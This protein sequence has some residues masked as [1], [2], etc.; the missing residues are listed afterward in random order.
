MKIVVIAHY[1]LTGHTCKLF[2]TSEAKILNWKL[3]LLIPKWFG[4]SAR[5]IKNHKSS[6]PF[7]IMN[8]C[9]E[10]KSFSQWITFL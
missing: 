6:Y 8:V 5:Q 7:F 9:F 10:T 1:S 2:V 4:Y 3:P